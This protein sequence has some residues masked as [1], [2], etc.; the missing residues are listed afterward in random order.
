MIGAYKIAR[1]NRRVRSVR[2]TMN[3]ELQEEQADEIKIKR[4]MTLRFEE[5]VE[6][7][8]EDRSIRYGYF[9]NERQFMSLKVYESVILI[10][11]ET[12]KSTTNGIDTAS[13]GQSVRRVRREG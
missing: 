4:I 3:H 11:G 10:A 1:G 2:G 13:M 5:Q 8:C 6:C 12:V 9:G 7:C